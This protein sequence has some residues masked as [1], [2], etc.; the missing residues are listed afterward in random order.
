MKKKQR[1]LFAQ[2]FLSPFVTTVSVNCLFLLLICPSLLLVAP[3]SG[4]K[5]IIYRNTSATLLRHTLREEGS[6]RLVIQHSTTA[7]ATGVV[8]SPRGGGQVSRSNGQF[9]GNVEIYHNNRWGSICDD[10]WDLAEGNV[11][12]R[13][14]GFPDGADRVT[15]NGYFGH[16]RGKYI[17]EVNLFDTLL[18]KISSFVCLFYLPL[19]F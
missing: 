14:L 15:H 1:Q 4:L 2:L 16:G 3:V 13:S 10:E 12:C 5:R 17:L 18:V 11:A 19:T 8:N 9:E 6:I 7:K